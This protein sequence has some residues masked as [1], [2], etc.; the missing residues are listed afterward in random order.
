MRELTE[1][2]VIALASA[3]AGSGGGGGGTGDGDMK[4]SVYDSSEEVKDAGGI[5]A[6]VNAEV[7]K[8]DGTISG[9]P[10][11]GKTVTALSE[12]NGKVS[13]TF[14]AI[15]ITKSQ[16]SD[17]GASASYTPAGSVSVTQGTDTT[18]TVNSITDVGTLPSFSYAN[19]TLTFNE[20]TLPTKGSDTTVV[21][22]SGSRTASFSGT[23]ATIT[24]T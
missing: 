18:T 4:M 21:T 22:A 2:D 16:V 1:A 3:V 11:A 14:G 23:A 12:T 7:N 6:F 24:S 17:F 5:K 9:T 8:L 19:E 20:G 10:G 13:A 15:E